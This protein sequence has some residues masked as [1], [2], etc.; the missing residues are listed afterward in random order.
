MGLRD[1]AV[2]AAHQ[3]RVEA[4]AAISAVCFF[5]RASRG[6][7]PFVIPTPDIASRMV[8]D[9]ADANA[10]SHGK[11]TTFVRLRPDALARSAIPQMLKL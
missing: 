7:R 8:S 5:F 6:H 2:G 10:F 9:A 1:I 3:C 11:I 4:S